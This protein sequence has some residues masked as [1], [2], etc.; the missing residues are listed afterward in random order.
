[1]RGSQAACE[2]SVVGAASNDVVDGKLFQYC[3]EPLRSSSMLTPVYGSA[4]E[5]KASEPP[6]A[7]QK[8]FTTTVPPPMAKAS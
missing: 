2:V 8:G 6:L 7:D 5:S 3:G 1:V 4:A